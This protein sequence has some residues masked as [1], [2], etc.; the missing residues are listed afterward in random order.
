MMEVF[1]RG[2]EIFFA[3]NC[4]GQCSSNSRTAQRQV[5]HCL[6]SGTGFQPVQRILYFRELN[7]NNNDWTGKMPVPPHFTGSTLAGFTG[8]IHSWQMKIPG[9]WTGL[10]PASRTLNIRWNN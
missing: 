2:R 9:G 7:E 10:N 4:D 3:M 1:D 5:I 6:G 8:K